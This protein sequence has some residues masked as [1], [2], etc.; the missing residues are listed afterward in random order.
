M[1]HRDLL[2]A[3]TCRQDFIDDFLIC[4]NQV[5]VLDPPERVSANRRARARLAASQVYPG[6]PRHPRDDRRFV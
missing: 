6:F 1:V 3:A 5:T 4:H 2:I